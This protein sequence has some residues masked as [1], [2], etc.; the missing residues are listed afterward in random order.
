MLRLRFTWL[1]LTGRVEAAMLLVCK[2]R[3]VRFPVT[4]REAHLVRAGLAAARLTDSGLPMRPKPAPP[5]PPKLRL[6][7]G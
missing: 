4:S 2:N 6:V 7:Q 1:V 3:D 5:P